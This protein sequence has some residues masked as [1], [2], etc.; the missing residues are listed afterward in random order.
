MSI[1]LR[2]TGT[3]DA[4]LRGLI[5]ACARIGQGAALREI[6]K[7]LAPVLQELGDRPWQRRASPMGVSWAPRKH[8]Y[9]H[10]ILEKSRRSR[11]SLR[12]RALGT[13]VVTTV[14]TTYARFH[15]SGTRSMAARPIF[16]T[17]ELPTAWRARLQKTALEALKEAFNG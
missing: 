8:V 2:I 13:T 7:Q 15:Q 3:S 5:D 10:S 11:H 17:A 1:T 9:A 6:A 14:S 16:P 4:A 12:S